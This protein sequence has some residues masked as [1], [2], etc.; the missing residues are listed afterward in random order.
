MSKESSVNI[1][2]CNI[3]DVC[4]MVLKQFRRPIYGEITAIFES[5]AAIQI[6]TNTDGF[7]LAPATNCFWEEKDAKTFIKNRK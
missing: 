3:G 2:E 7:R 5:E 4:W 6:L 1:G